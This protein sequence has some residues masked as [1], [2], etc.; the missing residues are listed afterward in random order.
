MKKPT[1]FSI[2]PRSKPFEV[3]VLVEKDTGEAVKSKVLPQ[4]YYTLQSAWYMAKN[5]N[6]SVQSRI[7]CNITDRYLTDAE[8]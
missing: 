1:M 6:Y 2:R 4:H 8:D 5:L 7:Y 3:F